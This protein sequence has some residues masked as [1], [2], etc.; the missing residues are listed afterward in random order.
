MRSVGASREWSFG[1]PTL[2]GPH[3]GWG[4][5]ELWL[6]W[7]GDGERTYHVTCFEGAD[8]SVMLRRVAEIRSIGYR[9]LPL[10]GHDI[11]G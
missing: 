1:V 3:N 11:P 10:R 8:R 7:R 4:C 2:R 9:G 6:A 5:F